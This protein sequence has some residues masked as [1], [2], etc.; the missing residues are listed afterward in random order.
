MTRMERQTLAVK[1]KVLENFHVKTDVGQSDEKWMPE[2]WEEILNNIRE[3]RRN[4]DAPVDNM[5]C[6]QCPDKSCSPEVGLHELF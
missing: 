2:N 3:M 1:A 4:R 6:E 5:G